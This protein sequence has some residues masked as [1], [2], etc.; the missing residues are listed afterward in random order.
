MSIIIPSDKP[1][2]KLRKLSDLKG[3]GKFCCDKVPLL[4]I[5]LDHIIPDELHLMLRVTDVMIEALIHTVVAFD[6]HQ[7]YEAG[8]RRNVLNVLEGSMLTKLKTVMNSCGI[9][10]RIWKEKNTNGAL[11]WTSLMGPD[12]LKLLRKL[13]SKLNSTCHPT[14][15][16]SDV[17]ALWKVH[18][19]E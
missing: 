16:V 18:A 14:E 4:Q 8:C 5:A 11:N 6:I 9:P 10:F 1:D 7:H 2:V 12:K 13:P 15:M 17:Q 3:D 19:T